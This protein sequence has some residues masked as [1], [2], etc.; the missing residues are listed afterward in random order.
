MWRDQIKLVTLDLSTSYQAA[1]DPVLP[2][3]TK[4]AAPFH[5]VNLVKIAVD[6]CRRRA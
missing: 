4:V 3:A 2:H 6:E 5:V 1:F